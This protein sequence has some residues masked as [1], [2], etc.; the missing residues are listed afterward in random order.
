MMVDQ[1]GFLTFIH[2]VPKL[3]HRVFL[4][5]HDCVLIGGTLPGDFRK[6]QGPVIQQTSQPVPDIAMMWRR[7]SHEEWWVFSRIV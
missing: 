3:V 5:Q 2:H 1:T 6:P 4:M 7:A